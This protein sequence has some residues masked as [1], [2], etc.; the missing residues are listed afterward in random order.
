MIFK[1]LTNRITRNSSASKYVAGYI[2]YF[3]SFVLVIQLP[4]LHTLQTGLNSSGGGGNTQIVCHYSKEM[5]EYVFHYHNYPIVSDQF[6][7]VCMISSSLLSHTI[8][9]QQTNLQQRTSAAHLLWKVPLNSCML[10]RLP[11]L[12]AP[13]HV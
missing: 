2:L 3:L 9:V 7:F 12:R 1:K 10:T 8:E 11:L 13:P 4:Y 6:C 5:N